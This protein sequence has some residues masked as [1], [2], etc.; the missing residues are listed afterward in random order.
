MGIVNP[1]MLEIYDDIPKDLLE[2]REDVLFDRKEDGPRAN[3]LD[4]AE[5]LKSSGRKKC[6]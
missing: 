3:F 5:R 4:F 2:S 1:T 6:E